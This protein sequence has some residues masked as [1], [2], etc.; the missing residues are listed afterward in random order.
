MRWILLGLILVLAAPAVAGEKIIYDN[1]GNAWVIDTET[2]AT[3]GAGSGEGALVGEV[4]DTVAAY[5]N[6]KFDLQIGI[7]MAGIGSDGNAETETAITA[8]SIFYRPA[9]WA[10][11]GPSLAWDAVDRTQLDLSIPVSFKLF[12]SPWSSIIWWCNTDVLPH[13]IV[14]MGEGPEPRA[15]AWS[16]VPNVGISIEVPMETF[17]VEGGVG[18]GVPLSLEGITEEAE[19]AAINQLALGAEVAFNFRW[20]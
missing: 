18:V 14:R 8:I 19:N 13:Y 12:P 16:W 17:S 20:R 15:S 9:I 3:P 1:D 6:H 10:R 2:A 4:A 11:F 7:T 5:D